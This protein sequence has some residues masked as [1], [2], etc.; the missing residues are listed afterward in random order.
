MR[1]LGLAITTVLVLLAAA[2]VSPLAASASGTT[3][4]PG[5]PGPKTGARSPFTV[6]APSAG[7]RSPASVASASVVCDGQFDA[8]SSPNGTGDNVLESTAAVSAN[9]VWTVGVQTNA[10]VLDRTLAEHWNGT[11]WSIVPTVNPGSG[12]NDLFGVSA[13]TSNN[14][15]AVGA[16]ETNHATAA[17]A[18]LAEH[19]NGTSWSTVATPNP[20]TYSYLFAVSAVSSTSVWAV[21][22]AYNFLVPGYIPMI[23][24]F[25]GLSWSSSFPPGLGLG[26]NQLFAVSALSDSSIWAVGSYEPTFGGT[27]QSFADY[28]DGSVW[29]MVLPPNT[30]VGDNEILGVTALEVG[31]ALGVGYGGNAVSTSPRQAIG[32]DLNYPSASSSTALSAS[33]AGDVV[34]EAVARASDSVWAVG[35]TRATNSSPLQ[36]LVRAATW[37]STAHS[38]TW[39]SSPGTSANPGAVNSVLLGVAAI[40]PSVFWA[41]GFANSGALDQTLTELYC[42]LHFNLSAPATAIASVPFSLSLTAKNADNSTAT[43]YRG[44]VHFTSSDSHA[45]LPPDYTFTPGDAGVHT[46][47]GVVLKNP[48]NQPSTI[49]V[50]DTVTPFVSATAAITVHCAGVCQSPAGTPGAGGPAQAPPTSPGGRNAGQSPGG[51]PGPRLSRHS[52]AL[53][54]LPAAITHLATASVANTTRMGVQ[55]KPT[56]ST[57]LTR[58]TLPTRITLPTRATNSLAPTQDGDRLLVSQR[59]VASPPAA[60]SAWNVGLVVPLG[61]LAIALLALRRRRNEEE[62]NVHDRP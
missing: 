26:D 10:S 27:R 7:I 30:A 46:F 56:R 29:H 24:H 57:V 59:T 22:T 62:S 18:T 13:V 16:Y 51:S 58:S 55:A 12:H 52:A 54:G 14:V 60:E 40:S 39:A 47:T 1:K 44:T 6:P 4:L 25:D 49:T 9:D 50:S 3:H 8:V 31:H 20:S 2:F 11:S 17:S 61:L 34:F 41:V 37:D 21:G 19:W 15:W 43:G 23:E 45:V 36:T 33:I 28:W 32:W 48:Y 38:L 53:G 5:P 42:A 35:F